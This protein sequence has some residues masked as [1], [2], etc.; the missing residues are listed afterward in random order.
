MAS[1]LPL[2][3]LQS[4]PVGSALLLPP[5][6]RKG[7]FCLSLH[8]TCQQQGNGAIKCIA[9]VGDAVVAVGAEEVLLPPNFTFAA[10]WRDGLLR[11]I[12]AEH[13]TTGLS[14]RLEETGVTAVLLLQCAPT[15]RY[16]RPV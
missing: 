11:L 10:S 5:L 7:R 12:E 6:S 14:F 15:R 4:Y 2:P 3:H 1:T 8:C 9:I 13:N 16:T